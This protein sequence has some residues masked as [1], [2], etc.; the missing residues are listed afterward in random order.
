M[1]VTSSTASMDVGIAV[2]ANG[3]DV[4]RA[5][6]AAPPCHHPLILVVAGEIVCIIP[7]FN[8]QQYGLALCCQTHKLK[9]PL[10][11]PLLRLL[12]HR[13]LERLYEC[14]P[15]PKQVLDR[16]PVYCR[17]RNMILLANGMNDIWL[18]KGTVTGE[19]G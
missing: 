18:A 19:Y 2:R 3:L 9:L 16:P 12:V 7:P 14:L 6:P 10:L 5:L 11:L 8:L 15:R 1:V 4:V 13:G 17:R